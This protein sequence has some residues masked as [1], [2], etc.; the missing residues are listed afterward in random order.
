MDALLHV[1]QTINSYLSDY[2]LIILLIGAGLFFSIRTRFVQVRCFGEGVRRMFGGFSLK[3]KKQAGGMSSFQALATAVAA[4]VGTGNIVGACGAILVG[5][6]G[7]ILW[8]WLIA[9]FGMATNYAEAV[10]AQTTRVVDADGR[11][12]GGPVYYIKEAFKGRFGTFL[13]GFFGVA[14]ILALGFMGCMVQSNSI[15]STCNT[16]FGI[17]LWVMGALVVVAA[18]LVFFGG[19]SRIAAVTEKVVPFMALIYLVGGVIVLAAHAAQVPE[20]VALIF[21]CAF[22]PQAGVGGVTFGIFAAISQ[23][24]KRG[25]FSNEAGMGS[26]PH[27][28]ALAEVKDP[29]EQGVVAMIGV[30]VDTIIVVTMTALVVLS[31]LYVGDGTLATG[32]YATLTAETITKTNIAQLAFG[33]FFGANVGAW[34][35]AI[36]LLFFAFSTILSWNLFA[37]LNVEWLFGKKAVLPFTIIALAFIF[38]GS[39]LS[40]DLVWELA[41]MFNQLMVIPNAI[42]LFALSGAVLAIANAKHDKRALDAAEERLEDQERAAINAMVEEDKRK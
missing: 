13:A 38:M 30:F 10:L 20:T 24:A 21:Q 2:V 22:N 16:A 12:H 42:A 28:H 15:A 34:F 23:G 9:F 27:A 5:G 14:I 17:P 11:V 18:G 32:D 26:T 31:V 40:N 3:G 1:V 8:M 37:K 33:Q 7:A 4:Q 25:L 35:V 6:P 36:C 29:H 39:L 41:D 19:T